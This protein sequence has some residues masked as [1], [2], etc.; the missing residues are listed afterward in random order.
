MKRVTAASIEA[1]EGV[2][3]PRERGRICS[4]DAMV[5]EDDGLLSAERVDD[6]ATFGVVEDYASKGIVES[7]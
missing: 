6:S 5:G 4:Q 2:R 7:L 1:R 3:L